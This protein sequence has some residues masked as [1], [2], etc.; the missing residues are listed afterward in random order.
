MHG[1]MHIKKK[2]F[3]FLF[4]IRGKKEI[5][6][7]LC[8]KVQLHAAW[9]HFYQYRPYHNTC[10]VVRNSLRKAACWAA[11][12]RLAGVRRQANAF[13]ASAVCF[14]FEA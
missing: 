9:T 4:H 14:K 2:E 3:Y 13:V 11:D 1:P 8:P 7:L 12:C 10:C 6:N 5:H